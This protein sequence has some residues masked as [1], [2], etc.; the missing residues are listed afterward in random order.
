MST[1][2]PLFVMLDEVILISPTPPWY[3][4]PCQSAGKVHS[5]AAS[6]GQAHLDS[7]DHGRCTEGGS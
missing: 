2:T 6:E 5:A 7:G 1:Q 4:A 3:Q